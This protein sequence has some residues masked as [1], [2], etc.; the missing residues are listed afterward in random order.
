[1]RGY[2]RRNVHIRSPERSSEAGEPLVQRRPAGRSRGP[3]ARRRCRTS[4][5]WRAGGRGSGSSAGRRR[6][7][8][9]SSPRH[10]DSTAAPA[11]TATG[12]GTVPW[13]GS[14]PP[15][16][17]MPLTSSRTGRGS[18]EVMKY[19]RPAQ[20]AP[21]GEPVGGVEVG[22]G[23]VVDV[24]GVDDR[25]PVADEAQP[26]R[27]RAVE[28]PRRRAGCRR[29]PTPGAGAAR[30]SPGRGR[31]RRAPG[32][33]PRPSSRG[34]PSRSGW[35]RA[36]TRRRR[37]CR[38][39]ACTTL[40]VLVK[41]NRPI[42]ASRQASSSTRVPSTLLWRKSRRC[43][44][45][46]PWRRRGRRRR[47]PATAAVRPPGR[48]GRRAPSCTPRSRSARVVAAGEARRRRRRGPAGRRRRR[49]RGSHRRR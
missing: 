6:R 4:A 39:P 31:S 32:A 10:S 33:R 19:G 36:A 11:A 28:D 23:G 18:P 37:R 8:T 1:M 40:G 27:A 7:V 46:R 49:R 14:S 48:P 29:G 24:G 35:R 41:T 43:P 22:R 2:G 25:R 38:R 47:S 9:R 42:P 3:G 13:T 17:R 34:R 16:T 26:P 5:R 30:R 21:G 44:R 45:C 20:A 15:A 12:S